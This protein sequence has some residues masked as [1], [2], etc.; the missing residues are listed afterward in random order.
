MLIDDLKDKYKFITDDYLKLLNF[1]DHYEAIISYTLNNEWNYAY[2]SIMG[3]CLEPN[4]TILWNALM[5]DYIMHGGVRPAQRFNDEFES[6]KV[7]DDGVLSN[8]EELENEYII[9]DETKY[10]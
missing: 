4:E 6:F 7:T 1:I 5:C 9:D 8:R 2:E 3:D 10:E